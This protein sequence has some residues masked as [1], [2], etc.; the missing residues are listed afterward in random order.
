MKELIEHKHGAMAL[1]T[2]D[3]KETMRNW[4]NFPKKRRRKS[5]W[6]DFD[7]RSWDYC[8]PSHFI[9]HRGQSWICQPRPE[10]FVLGKPGQCVQ[11]SLKLAMKHPEL[12][13]VEGVAFGPCGLAAHAWTVDKYWR[14]IDPTWEVGESFY[15]GVAFKTSYIRQVCVRG[16][17]GSIIWNWQDGWPLLRGLSP[18]IWKARIRRQR[19]TFPTNSPTLEGPVRRKT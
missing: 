2:K 4:D 15:F 12:F 10:K 18:Q 5:W 13:Y 3:V 7:P 8:G 17:R 11:A 9:L 19:P 1:L 6:L 14:I 16:F